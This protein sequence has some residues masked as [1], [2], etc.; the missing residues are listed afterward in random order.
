MN[1]VRQFCMSWKDPQAILLLFPN[2]S[3]NSSSMRHPIESH[4]RPIR[5]EGKSAIF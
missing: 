1:F 5:D 4:R 3:N 2:A